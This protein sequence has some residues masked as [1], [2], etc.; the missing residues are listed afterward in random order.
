MVFFRLVP[1]TFA[2][3]S[4]GASL[5]SRLLASGAVNDEHCSAV[6][7]RRWLHAPCAS[8]SLRFIAGHLTMVAANNR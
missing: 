3:G 4:S 8:S 2:G 6:P 5:Q 7:G 1:E